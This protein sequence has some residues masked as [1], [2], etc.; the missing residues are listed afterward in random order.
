MRSPLSEKFSAPQAERAFPWA[1]QS[2]LARY[3]YSDYLAKTADS[4]AEELKARILQV[5][6]QCCPLERE[7]DY[8]LLFSHDQKTTEPMIF[9]Y[10]QGN[11]SDLRRKHVQR[12]QAES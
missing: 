4:V 6:T 10:N 7:K 12:S 3:T 8:H 11:F 1:A 9:R 5:S 2:L